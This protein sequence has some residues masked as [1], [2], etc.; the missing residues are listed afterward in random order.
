M[1]A[2]KTIAFFGASAGC[3]HSALL[4][5]LASGHTCLALLRV[6][7]KLSELAAQ[8]PET[9]IIK[10]GNAHNVA[11]VASV[12]SH[13][14]RM[15]DSVSFSIGNKPDMKTMKL[16]D[17]EVCQKGMKALLEAL[18]GLRAQGVQGR[19]LMAVC[20]T[21]GLNEKRDYPLL[22][23]PIYHWLLATPHADKRAMEELLSKSGERYV[24]VR[25]SLLVD[26]DNKESKVRVGV[27]D[28][29]TGEIEEKEV[30]Y[31]ISRG[32]VGRWVF[33]KVLDRS[34]EKGY[35]GKAVS[36]TW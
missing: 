28:I 32:A 11:E 12:L 6:P 35:E 7:S 4:T 10:E 9:L 26:G 22:F 20:S 19:P 34:D 2:H 15:V 13:E 17:P 14:G 21:T 1:S 5:A 29:R 33:L 27:E 24:V 8:Y 30:G 16:A 18:E 23:Y 3:G 31:T 36:L 25:P